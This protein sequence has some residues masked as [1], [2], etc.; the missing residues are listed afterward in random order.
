MKQSGGK[1]CREAPQRRSHRHLHSASVHSVRGSAHRPGLGASSGREEDEE[2]EDGRL[3]P[4]KVSTTWTACSSRSCHIL[5]VEPQLKFKHNYFLADTQ[6]QR[7]LGDD[8]PRDITETSLAILG[9]SDCTIIR[10]SHKHN[11]SILDVARQRKPSLRSF[12]SN[13]MYWNKTGVLLCVPWS[14]KVNL[15]S[16]RQLGILRPVWCPVAAEAP[17]VGSSSRPAG[18]FEAF[19]LPQPCSQTF[20]SSS[21]SKP[22]TSYLSLADLTKFW[23][24]SHDRRGNFLCQRGLLFPPCHKSV[25]YTH[26][27]SISLIKF[28][29]IRKRS[30]SGRQ[31]VS[32]LK[33]VLQIWL[34]QT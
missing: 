26:L 10:N 3:K 6:R 28:Y 30:S 13:V 33:H 16:A 27:I 23:Q 9:W 18:P 15:L 21:S 24:V 5:I 2:E 1:V 31:L 7:C 25:Y 12:I 32:H 14:I 11:P 22:I 4:V 19:G 17:S 29:F 8:Q 34:L 20:V